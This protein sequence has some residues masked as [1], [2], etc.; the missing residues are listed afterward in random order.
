MRMITILNEAAQALFD[1]KGSNILALDVR[2]IS[3]YLDY[4]IIAQ[5]NV[6]RHVRALAHSVEDQLKKTGMQPTRKE[7]ERDG[8]W[9]ILDYGS[10]A[11]HVMTEE[12]RERYSLEELWRE[13]DVVNLEI[14]TGPL[15]A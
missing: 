11:V 1:K 8:D 9:V 13:A 3:S 7:G 5:G 14:K 2:K 12:M 6:D 10:F 15:T 4:V